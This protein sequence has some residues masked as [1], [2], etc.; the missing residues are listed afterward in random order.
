[1]KYVVDYDTGANAYFNGETAGKTATAQSGIYS[2]GE[3]LLNTWF[4]GFYPYSSPEYAIVVMCEGGESGSTD[5]VR[6]SGIL[7]KK[8]PL[9]HS[10]NSSVKFNTLTQYML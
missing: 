4:T 1:M 3:E 9:F 5:V 6:F 2:D 7:L 8:F 10:E